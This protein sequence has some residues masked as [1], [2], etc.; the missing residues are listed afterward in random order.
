MTLRMGDAVT[1]ANLPQGLDVYAG[2]VGGRWPDY[3][4]M[5]VLFPNARHLS[6]AVNSGQKADCLDVET[7][8][9]V[10]GDVPF[11]LAMWHRANT[12]KPVLYRS[13]S[14]VSDIVQVAGPRD[15]YLI[16]S[17]H[18]T[19]KPHI[20]TSAACWP[21]SP[22]E[23][24]ADAT[25]WS[26]HGGIWDESLLSDTF[27][28]DPIPGGHMPR[29]PLPAAALPVKDVKVSSSQP[30]QWDVICLG[31]DGHPYHIWYVTGN[32]NWF[33]PE[34]LSKAG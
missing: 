27:F 21:I 9:A 28:A 3:Q 11:W 23:W 17:A 26:D 18:Y 19:D 8:D 13:T 15:R 2:Y 32:G 24:E 14:M 10:P 31:A 22:V 20:C 25:Q 7:G 34:D 1:P 4:S 6:I 5:T 30:G 29:N 12:P 33:G 16:W